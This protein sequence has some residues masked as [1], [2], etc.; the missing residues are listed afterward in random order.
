[1]IKGSAPKRPI[2]NQMLETTKSAS[3]RPSRTGTRQ[4]AIKKGSAEIA[5]IP[6]ALSM[7]SNPCW[8][9]DASQPCSGVAKKPNTPQTAI[10]NAKTNNKRP[11]GRAVI[12]ASEYCLLLPIA[13]K[14]GSA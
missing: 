5:V 4:L 14:T 1:M 10:E 13:L 12:R 9:C 11:S 3:R 7:C 2:A 6:A 8:V